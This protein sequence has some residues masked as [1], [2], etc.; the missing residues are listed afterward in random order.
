MKYIYKL[1]NR[2]LSFT[3]ASL[4]VCITKASP[5]TSEKPIHKTSPRFLKAIRGGHVFVDQID[6]Q[7]NLDE[8]DAMT[9]THSQLMEF[10]RTEIMGEFDFLE[11]VDIAKANSFGKKGD[12]FTY[13]TEVRDDYAD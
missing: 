2:A 10:T 5:L 11:E 12:C 4:G 6:E 3:D 9:A 7:P 1:G 8:L 13:L